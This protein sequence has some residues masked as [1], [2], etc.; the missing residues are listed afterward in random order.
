MII[1]ALIASLL[2]AAASLIGA[3][4]FGSNQTIA[5]SE[6][7]IVPL[8]VGVFLALA[9]FELI[10][11]TLLS[12]PELGGVAVMAGFVTFYMLSNFLHKRFHHL[13]ADECDKKG[14]ASLILIGDAVH[15]LADGFIL[16]GAFLVDPAVG[17]AVAFG[18]AIHEIPQEIVE[19]GVLLRAGYNR[20]QAAIRNLI[21]ASTIVFGTLIIILIAEHA[22]EYVW[23]LTGFAAGNLLYLAASDLL[24][25]IHGQLK[26]YGGMNKAAIFIVIGFMVMA[27]VIEW[28]H[29]T[30]GH[31]HEHVEDAEESED[32]PHEDE[33]L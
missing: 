5:K 25:R 4:I 33:T 12:A 23:L 6:R 27:G 21:S 24:P 11:E 26:E 31:G 29:E 13:E 30:F 10:P 7:V 1:D 3:F 15:N 9:L 19:F 18:L 22:D 2:V 32:H 14:A 8:A 16:G 20:T 17:V 28:T